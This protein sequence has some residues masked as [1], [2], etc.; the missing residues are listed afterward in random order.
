MKTCEDCGERIYE[1][2]CVN[3]R[4]EDYIKNQE[5]NSPSPLAPEPEKLSG[6]TINGTPIEWYRPE[7]G[8]QVAG[9]KLKRAAQVLQDTIDDLPKSRLTIE[10]AMSR[11]IYDAERV[12]ELLTIQE[13]TN[14]GET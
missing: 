1:H 14:E 10:Q 12:L 7:V 3:C 4:E 13:Q 6:E 2:G 9:E 11:L 5:G 8:S